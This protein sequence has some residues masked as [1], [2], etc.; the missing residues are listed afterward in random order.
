MKID[1]LQNPLGI[2]K[3]FEIHYRGN[4]CLCLEGRIYARGEE[5]LDEVNWFDGEVRYPGTCEIGGTKYDQF[6]KNL[7]KGAPSQKEAEQKM[8]KWCKS[9]SLKISSETEETKGIIK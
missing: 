6:Y 3:K 8:R 9:F 7:K 2:V 4:N 5:G 1:Y